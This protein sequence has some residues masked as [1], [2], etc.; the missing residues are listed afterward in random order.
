MFA[1]LNGQESR[2]P[3]TTHRPA[4]VG[5]YFKSGKVHHVSVPMFRRAGYAFC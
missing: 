3:M 2:A 1:N 4:G 5:R